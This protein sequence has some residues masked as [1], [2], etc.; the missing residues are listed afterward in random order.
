MIDED[1]MQKEIAAGN[2]VIT[3]GDSSRDSVKAMF[4]SIV[5]AED[6]DEVR[7]RSAVKSYEAPRRLTG[8]SSD[9]ARNYETAA[10]Y[11]YTPYLSKSFHTLEQ[12]PTKAI[13]EAYLWALDRVVEEDSAS[14]RLE[15][16]TRQLKSGPYFKMIYQKSYSTG[17]T[18]SPYGK[19]NVWTHYDQV[20]NDGNGSY[21]FWN[22]AFQL[23][24]VP[25]SIAFGSA[26]HTADMWN[27][28]DVNAKNSRF[29]LVTYS[30]TSTQ[31]TSTVGVNVGFTSSVTGPSA[32]I[33]ASWSYAISDV[34]V[35]DQSDFGNGVVSWWHDVN[36]NAT[37]GNSTYL[38][39]PGASIRVPQGSTSVWNSLPEFY[40]VQWHHR[41][42]GALGVIC[43]DYYEKVSLQY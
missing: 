31:G 11:Y 12:N 17:S 37:V 40:A 35:H 27:S 18:Y 29:F 15:K 28:V 13:E 24:S 16:A 10:A 22:I 43:H 19:I 21:D 33:G 1:F 9:G 39:Q 7:S 23:Q 34:V 8:I 25:G 3:V 14:F 41:T 4:E 42:C 26:W 36:E 20:L 5:G 30:P 32:T 38:I 2:F 6:M